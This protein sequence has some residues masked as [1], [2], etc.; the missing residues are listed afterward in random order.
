MLLGNA[1]GQELPLATMK[2]IIIQ[3]LEMRENSIKCILVSWKKSCDIGME[4]I[5]L[6]R[7]EPG[8]FF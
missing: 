4:I 7:V 2:K 6:S 1:E 5:S 8:R 3:C